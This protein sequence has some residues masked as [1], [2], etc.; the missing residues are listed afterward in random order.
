[1]EVQMKRNLFPFAI[2]CLLLVQSNA[3]SQSQ[4]KPLLR[5]EV[6]AEF[7]SLGRDAVTGTRSELGAGG[8]FTFNLNEIFALEGAAYIYPHQCFNCRENGVMS[9]AVAGVKIGKRFNSWGLFGKARPGLV[10]FSKGKTDV[11][12]TNPT[13]PSFDVKQ[14]SLTSFATDVGAVLEFYPSP[15]IVTRFD[16]GDTIVFFRRQRQDI[17][18]FDPAGQLQVFP[19]TR[20]ARTDHHFQFNASVGFRF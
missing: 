10:S 6:A 2:A 16:A 5:Y 7:S 4:S 9:E 18:I 19:I 11:T 8:R 1:M 14:D 13:L 15:R 20:P 3:L 12:V 17:L